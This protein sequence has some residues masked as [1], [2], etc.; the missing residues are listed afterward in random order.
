MTETLIVDCGTTNLRVTLLNE[1][2]ETTAAQN[3][4]GGVRCTAID[5][6][7]LRL[8][9]MLKEAISLVMREGKA[10]PENIADCIAYGMITSNMGLMEIPH[11]AAPA[12]VKELKNGIREKLFPDIAPFPIRFIPGVKN[13]AADVTM[14]NYAQMDMMRGEETEAVGLYALLKLQGPALFILPGSH[15]KF[16]LMG[17]GGVIRGCMTSIS[18]ELLDAVTHHTVIA[19][20]VGG[21][22]AREE[23]YLP[24]AAAEGAGESARSGLGRAAFAGRIL[25]TLGG[26]TKPE[27]QSYLLGAVLAQDVLAM[28]RFTGNE[29]DLPVFVAGKLPVQQAMCDV[30][31]ALHAGSAAAVPRELSARMGVFGALLIAS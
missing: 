15:N 24:E 16:V 8:R 29:Q 20:S 17:G 22:F 19:D 10:S 21:A 4:P 9:G 5:G 11:L 2:G 31:N 28:K 30:M 14:D 23:S 12:G 3:M 25:N 6:N 1:Q 18:G 13:S 26:K 7:D 27:V